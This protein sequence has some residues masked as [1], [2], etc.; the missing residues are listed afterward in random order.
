[1]KIG[2]LTICNIYKLPDGHQPLHVLEYRDNDVNGGTLT[3]GTEEN[4]IY[5]IFYAKEHD[6]F[7][8]AAWRCD[9]NPD[10]CFVTADDRHTPIKTVQTILPDFPHS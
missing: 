6:S 5:L 1:M 10:L 2:E 9:D 7:R 3:D 4:S 8:S